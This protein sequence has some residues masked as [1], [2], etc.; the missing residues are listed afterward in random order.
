MDKPP[1]YF[2]YTQHIPRIEVEM[3]DDGE[4]STDALQL[5]AS[6]RDYSIPLPPHSPGSSPWLS[7]E[8]RRLY[9]PTVQQT[10]GGTDDTG[11]LNPIPETGGRE[12]GGRDGGG[13]GASRHRH[14]RSRSTDLGQVRSGLSGSDIT[15]VYPPRPARSSLDLSRL[16]GRD[17][18]TIL[19]TGRRIVR[20]A[21]AG[22]LLQSEDLRGRLTRIANGSKPV[23][24]DRMHSFPS[25]SKVQDQEPLVVEIPSEGPTPRH[26]SLPDTRVH[27][28]SFSASRDCPEPMEN[29]FRNGD[30]AAVEGFM[31]E[32]PSARS[33]HDVTDKAA[34]EDHDSGRGSEVTSV[35]AK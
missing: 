33:P 2:S 22:N 17:T 26:R 34:K 14:T 32:V 27:S 9:L 24:V 19:Q 7:W 18:E 3:A 21:S 12:G 4:S 30:Y 25:V 20:N 31:L 11:H 23:K 13:E 28:Q 8:R 1:D 16:P 35:Q 15:N 29:G 5:D 6:A 10:V